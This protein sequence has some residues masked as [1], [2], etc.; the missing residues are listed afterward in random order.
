MKK[1]QQ[2]FS[3]GTT[4]EWIDRETIRYTEGQSYVDIWVD[5][6]PG[7][8]SKGRVLRKSSLEQW[9]ETPDSTSSQFDSKKLAEII[10]K[11]QQYYDA[12]GVSLSIA[13][14]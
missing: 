4:L 5:F 14:D 2:E 13:D 6:A 8:F 1:S 3:D 10:D 9:T 12:L 11:V 7:F